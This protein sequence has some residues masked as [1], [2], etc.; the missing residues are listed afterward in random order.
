MQ[1]EIIKPTTPLH[2]APRTL[3]VNMVLPHTRLPILLVQQGR[4]S[5]TSAE[6]TARA[7]HRDELRTQSVKT[8]SQPELFLA[9]KPN[10]GR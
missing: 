9:C 10:H 5:L 4:F 3:E 2:A 7:G 8:S 6:Q 1:T